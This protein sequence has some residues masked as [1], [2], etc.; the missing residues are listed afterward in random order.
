M[1]CEPYAATI[2]KGVDYE[3][4]LTVPTTSFEISSAKAF[5]RVEVLEFSCEGDGCAA[6][7]ERLAAPGWPCSIDV[8]ETYW[9]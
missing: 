4:L 1:T 6:A 9:R 2:D 8:V 5:G 3:V 7:A